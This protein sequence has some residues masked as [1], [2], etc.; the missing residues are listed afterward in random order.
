M[1]T[2]DIKGCISSITS[3]INLIMEEFEI[4]K[5]VIIKKEQLPIYSTILLD[6]KKYYLNLIN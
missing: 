5:E 6:I 2:F 3:T 1:D 4:N